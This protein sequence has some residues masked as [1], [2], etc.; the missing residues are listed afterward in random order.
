MGPLALVS[1]RG[2]EHLRRTAVGR[3]PRE[4][5]SGG[6]CKED[7]AVVAPSDTVVR[8]CVADHLR[9]ATADGDLLERSIDREPHPLTIGRKEWLRGARRPGNRCGREPIH[10]SQIQ[11]RAARDRLRAGAG[12]GGKDDGAAVGRQRDRR[13]IA[14]AQRRSRRQLNRRLRDRSRARRARS[15]HCP[16]DEPSRCDD[17][18]DPQCPGK[19]R[20][21]RPGAGDPRASAR[22][23]RRVSRQGSQRFFDARCARRRCR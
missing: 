21:R 13:E 8:L 23:R 15:R 16:T 14:V 11:L 17:Q 9:G 10:P 4:A 6:G 1:V 2:R 7:R 22:T 3:H 18:D 20:R 19:A 12:I 5:G